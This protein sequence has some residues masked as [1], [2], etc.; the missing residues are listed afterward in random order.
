MDKPSNTKELRIFLVDDDVLCLQSYTHLLNTLGYNNI[1][2]YTMGADCLTHLNEQPDFIFLDYFMEDMT[3]LEVLQ[4]IKSV[5]PNIPVVFISAQENVEIM[6]QAINMGAFD[7]IVKSHI[8]A[9]CFKTTID[10]RDSNNTKANSSAKKT[11]F[12]RVSSALG[13]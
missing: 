13:I 3:G 10:N 11:I 12:G 5:S 2:C 9:N 6:V 8:S 1:A 7:Y 4:T